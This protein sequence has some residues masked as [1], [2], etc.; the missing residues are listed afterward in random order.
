MLKSVTLSLLQQQEYHFNPTTNTGQCI[1]RFVIT[2]VAFRWFR[3]S[4]VVLVLHWESLGSGCCRR[5][6]PP[7]PRRLFLSPLPRTAIAVAVSASPSSSEERCTAA[8]GI[9]DWFS[10]QL[11]GFIPLGL[12]YDTLL[13]ILGLSTTRN[14]AHRHGKIRM[15]FI[16]CNHRNQYPDSSCHR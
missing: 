16:T 14:S 5:D 6:T 2:L 11:S 3:V 1:R 10:F 13:V 7:T 4:S 9:A 15:H 12:F 8:A